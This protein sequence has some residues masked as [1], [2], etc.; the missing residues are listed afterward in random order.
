MSQF[1]AG[2]QPMTSLLAGMPD[3]TPWKASKPNI[4]LTARNGTHATHAQT[5]MLFDLSKPDASDEAAFNQVLFD[6]ARATLR[7]SSRD[8]ATPAR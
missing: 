2:A 8:E 4:A 6:Y 7:R 1:D 5:S 3:T